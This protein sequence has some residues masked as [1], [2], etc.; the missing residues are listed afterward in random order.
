MSLEFVQ[1]LSL[2]LE[3]LLEYQIGFPE[4]APGLQRLCPGDVEQGQRG[5]NLLAAQ[6]TV[7]IQGLVAAIALKRS[8]HLCNHTAPHR[9]PGK[10]CIST[11]PARP[12]DFNTSLTGAALGPVQRI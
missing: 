6:V 7:Q 4:A 3:P 2:A 5:A 12:K 10:I 8:K 11:P 9:G 1:R